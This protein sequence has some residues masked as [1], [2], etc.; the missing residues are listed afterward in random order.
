MQEARTVVVAGGT[1]QPVCTARGHC[2]TVCSQ[3]QHTSDAQFR[4]YYFSNLFYF[5]QLCMINFITFPP[6]FEVCEFKDQLFYSAGVEPDRILEFSC[7]MIN[8][9]LY[10]PLFARITITMIQ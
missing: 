2:D 9:I 10:I 5:F 8:L 1:M 7:G 3:H 6:T 4:P